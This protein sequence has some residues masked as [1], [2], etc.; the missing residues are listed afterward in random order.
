MYSV[1]NLAAS[2]KRNE[3]AEAKNEAK[4]AQIGSFAIWAGEQ[5]GWIKCPSLP[6]PLP[7]LKHALA[8]FLFCSSEK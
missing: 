4:C 1:G 6:P 2:Q 3:R 7:F 8:T 5:R